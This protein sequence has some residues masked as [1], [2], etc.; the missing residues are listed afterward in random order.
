[1]DADAW[2]AE[3][4]AIERALIELGAV[5]APAR[6]GS[7]RDRYDAARTCID[8]IHRLLLVR[9]EFVDV[10]LLELHA[11]ARTLRAAAARGTAETPM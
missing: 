6:I 8:V 5:I 9:T 4:R 1:M 2:E 7:W 3:L 11:R 10:P